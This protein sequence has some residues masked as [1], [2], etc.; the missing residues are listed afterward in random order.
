MLL[1][2]T[3]LATSQIIGVCFALLWYFF[4]DHH[5]PFIYEIA[6]WLI[7][8]TFLMGSSSALINATKLQHGFCFISY[9]ISLL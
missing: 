4:A 2:L 1:G 9:V 6:L 5:A 3:K 7:L 8:V